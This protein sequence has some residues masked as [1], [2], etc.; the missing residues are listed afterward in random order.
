MVSTDRVQINV[1]CPKALCCTLVFPTLSHDRCAKLLLALFRSDVSQSLACYA[2]K[3]EG[4]YASPF[5]ITAQTIPAI[6]FASATRTS[7]NG[8]RDSIL[9]SHVPG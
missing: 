3:T 1:A 4:R 9:A 2:A 8:L 5:F 6:L 7:I